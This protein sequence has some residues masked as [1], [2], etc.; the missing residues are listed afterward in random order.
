[1]VCRMAC[2]TNACYQLAS[3]DGW[4]GR[5]LPPAT[6]AHPGWLNARIL[7]RTT[8]LAGHFYI[9][10]PRFPDN[11]HTV[12]ANPWRRSL[13]RS[14]QESEQR[15]ACA[16]RSWRLP[17][18]STRPLPSSAQIFFLLTM[19]ARRLPKKTGNVDS[20]IFFS[21][22]RTT[23]LSPGPSIFRCLIRGM[24]CWP[25]RPSYVRP[26]QTAQSAGPEVWPWGGITCISCSRPG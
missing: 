16:A 11:G 20:L 5:S 24:Q 6:F 14:F 7:Q 17:C 2:Q 1:M 3:W 12:D 22:S 8:V 4:R 19:G 26:P 9:Q 18:S 13:R 15:R 23:R 21:N 10:D 25:T